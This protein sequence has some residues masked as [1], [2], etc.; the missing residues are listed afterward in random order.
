[1]GGTGAEHGGSEGN[2]V[3]GVRAGKREGCIFSGGGAGRLEVSG[4]RTLAG[5]ERPR[6]GAPAPAHHSKVGPGPG[7][8]V[9]GL[10]AAA[11]KLA[12]G[13]GGPDTNVSVDDGAG[14]AGGAGPVGGAPA[15]PME[16][17]RGEDRRLC[18]KPPE[19]QLQPFPCPA[20]PQG[21]GP[22]PPPP[23]PAGPPTTTT[24]R[25]GPTNQRC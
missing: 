18:E 7:E 25:N 5:G 11:V 2:R 20:R 23:P 4:A 10:S 6:P 3:G 16:A 24:E 19:P 8:G 12:G 21:P 9:P 14:A 15:G 13:E 22:D 1:M 17:K